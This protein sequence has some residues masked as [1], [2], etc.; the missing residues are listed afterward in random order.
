MNQKILKTDILTL[1]SFQLKEKLTI[2][3]FEPYR[4]KQVEEWLW[5]HGVRSFQEMNNLS[6]EQ[7]TT[8]DQIFRMPILSEDKVQQSGDGTMKFRFLLDDG[9]KIE[10]VLIPVD[11]DKRY[12]VCVSSQSGCSLSCT[13]CATGRMGL[14]RQLS[15]SEIFDQYVHVNK[16]CEQ[17]YKKP[18]SNIVYMGMGE[19]L[20]NYKNVVESIHRLS[21]PLG[22][23]ISPKRITVSTAGIAKMIIKLADDDIKVNLALSLHAADDQKRNEIMP[24]NQHNNLHALTQA[25]RYFSQKTGSRISYEY[26]AFEHFNDFEKDAKNLIKLCSH[27]PVKVNLIEYNPIRGIDYEKSSE[28]RINAFAKEIRSHG[29]MI[30]LRRSRGK[31]IDAACGQLANEG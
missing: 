30:T 3:G 8:L 28:D 31:D 1:S 13:F 7:R 12:T 14:L 10:S 23:N 25:L 27:F 18:L 26:I 9:N 15:A 21:S 29:I 6:K 5:K 22:P 2:L 4:S 20:L 16:V 19:P 24:I 11:E 17:K